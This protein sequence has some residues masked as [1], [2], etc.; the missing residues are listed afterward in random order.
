M[1]NPSLVS[2]IEMGLIAALIGS[3]AFAFTAWK[4]PGCGAL[5]LYA[6]VRI[7]LRGI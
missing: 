3:A 1:A 6:A 7:I 2:K 4:E 5:L